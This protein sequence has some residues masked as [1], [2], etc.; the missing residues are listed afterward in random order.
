MEIKIDTPNKENNLRELKRPPEIETPANSP[1]LTF[2]Q[3][4]DEGRSVTVPPDFDR[5]N[6]IVR[7]RE[8]NQIHN[9]YSCCGNSTDRRILNFVSQLVVST[10]V[11]LFCILKL[12]FSDDDQ[13]YYY[14][15][16]ISSILGYFLGL[17]NA[18]QNQNN[19]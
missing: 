8:R 14:I 2:R 11:L 6:T 13:N 3:M 7:E 10:I 9:V 12:I 18:P 15:G 19:N 4:I 5:E 1:L 17:V 16:T